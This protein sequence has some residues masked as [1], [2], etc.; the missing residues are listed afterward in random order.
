LI[1]NVFAKGKKQKLER[2]HAVHFP[3]RTLINEK[4]KP[5]YKDPNKQPNPILSTKAKTKANQ[6]ASQCK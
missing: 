4:R 1:F 5:N 2:K 6:G 3:R